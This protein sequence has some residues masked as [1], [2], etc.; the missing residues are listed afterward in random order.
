MALS[1]LR[2]PTAHTAMT[3]ITAFLAGVTVIGVRT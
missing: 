2:R 3:L 1:F